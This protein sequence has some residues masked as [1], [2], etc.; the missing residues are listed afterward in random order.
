MYGPEFLVWI[1]SQG[2]FATYF[3]SSKTARREAKKMEPL[4]GKAA[5]F[6]CKLIDSGRFKWHGPVVVPCSS[7]LEVPALDAIKGEVEKFQNPPKSDIEIADDASD[8]DRVR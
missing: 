8:S 3:M 6:R 4:L 1:P 2:V 5:T 7:P